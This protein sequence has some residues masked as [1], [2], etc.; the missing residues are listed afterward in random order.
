LRDVL[1]IT[2]KSP[3][4]GLDEA[5][6]LLISNRYFYLGA[7]IIKEYGRKMSCLWGTGLWRDN[8]KPENL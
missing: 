2:S 6:R 5:I 7:R 3:I 4:E 1:A 8:F